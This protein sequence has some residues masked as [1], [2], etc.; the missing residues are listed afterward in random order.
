MT[1]PFEKYHGTG[2]D[3][4]LIDN[5]NLQFDA[6]D[7]DLI[8]KMCSRRFGIGADGLMF[9]QNHDDM[10]FEMVYFN[11][12]GHESSMCGNG[13]R[14]ITAFAAKLNIILEKASF[15][16]V[17]GIH[18]SIM[19]PYGNVQL[20]M[21]DVEAVEKM[22]D[23]YILNT[24]SP[25][26]VIFKPIQIEKEII[27]AA[28]A[29]RYGP[30]FE[31]EGVNVN[32]VGIHD[33]TEI[34]VRTYERGVEDETLSCGTGVV[35]A[36]IAT[37]LYQSKGRVEYNI[38]TRGGNLSVRFEARNDHFE[39]IWLSGGAQFVFSGLYAK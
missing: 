18:E 13:G 24:G 26:Y 7:H 35:A 20:K 9:L 29:I 31:E 11:A 14:C 19:D 36:A 27:K 38:V 15:M 16:A 39:N 3:F 32:F 10:D 25:H 8:R 5:R 21:N 37:F 6:N 1:I 34:F 17:D 4:I 23:A 30:G 33:D 2:N 28:H 12:D 22:D